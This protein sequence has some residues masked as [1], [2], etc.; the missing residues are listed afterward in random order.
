MG[1]GY[2]YLNNI[3]YEFLNISYKQTI[4]LFIY[5]QIDIF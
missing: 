3:I 2:I 4:N 5:I 1:I